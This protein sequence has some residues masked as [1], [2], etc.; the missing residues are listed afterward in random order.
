MLIPVDDPARDKDGDNQAESAEAEHDACDAVP[1]RVTRHQVDDEGLV[2]PPHGR[3]VQL[4][5]R[6]RLVDSSTIFLLFS[7]FS[8]IKDR[9]G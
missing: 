3:P 5:R 6:L 1:N 7:C 8:F 9:V 4:Q 2:P